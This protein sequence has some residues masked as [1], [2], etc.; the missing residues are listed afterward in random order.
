VRLELVSWAL[1]ATLASREKNNTPTAQ[2]YLIMDL[3]L[4]L[5]K[6]TRNAA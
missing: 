1:P 6:V 3:P 5:T 2:Q 4:G